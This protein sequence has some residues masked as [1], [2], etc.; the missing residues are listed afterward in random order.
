MNS[1]ESDI[2]S[3]GIVNNNIIHFYNISSFFYS[4][5]GSTPL[6]YEIF[7]AIV[8]GCLILTLTGAMLVIIFARRMTKKK[9][10]SKELRTGETPGSTDSS[11]YCPQM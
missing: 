6:V 4:G 9:P 10:R 7:M 11:N 5:I 8:G 1:T 3:P 2:P